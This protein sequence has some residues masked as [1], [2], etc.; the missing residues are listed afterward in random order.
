MLNLI[1]EALTTKELLSGEEFFGMAQDVS[2]HVLGNW[3][4]VFLLKDVG[5]Y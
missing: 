5:E 3:F 2:K 4:E 1:Q